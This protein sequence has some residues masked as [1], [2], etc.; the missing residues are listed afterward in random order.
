MCLTQA[1]SMRPGAQK[2]LSCSLTYLLRM[3]IFC[4]V[5][6]NNNQWAQRKNEVGIITITIIVNVRLE[7]VMVEYFF[8]IQVRPWLISI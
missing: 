8:L 1:V 5:R 2:R 6:T 4:Y 3:V 7:K